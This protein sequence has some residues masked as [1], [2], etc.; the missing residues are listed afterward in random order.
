VKVTTETLPERQVKLQ[1]EVDEERHAQAIEQAYKRLAP[2]V[3]IP[4]FRPGKAPRPLIEKQLGRHRLLD[5]AMDQLIPVLYQE[6]LDEQSL[7]PIAQPSV[8]LVS[9]EPLVFTALVPLRP[10]VDLGDLS[11]LSIPR[12]TETVPD[13]RVEEAI[14]DLRRRYGTMEPVDREAQKGDI[15]R[16][17]VKAELEGEVLYEQD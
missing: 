16:G 2:R 14:T 10:E 15:I 8:E 7:T 6:A 3:R 4:G 12:E 9:H 17:N 1:I 13:E 5:E 11:A